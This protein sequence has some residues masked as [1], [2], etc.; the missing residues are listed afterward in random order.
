[1]CGTLQGLLREQYT[2]ATREYYGTSPTPQEK[3]W[4]RTMIEEDGNEK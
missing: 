4:G 1:M 2:R 3:A